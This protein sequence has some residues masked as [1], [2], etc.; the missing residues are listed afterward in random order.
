MVLKVKRLIARVLSNCRRKT[1]PNVHSSAVM[2]RDISVSSPKYLYL[3]EDCNIAKGAVIMNGSNGKFVMKKWSFSARELLVICGN[4]MPVVGVPLI[5]VTDAMKQQ[6]DVDHK[7]SA[8]VIVDEDVWIGARVTLMPGV[9]IG[10]GAIIAAGSVVTHCVPAY[11][12]WGGVPAKHIK[13]KW[14]LEEIIKHEK[15]LYESG[16]RFSE[17]ELKNIFD[18]YGK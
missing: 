12:V 18:K 15:I 11:S 4:H 7:Y 5:K 1:Y 3:G 16:S 10:R 14:T 6:L 13:F 9:H 8:D 2:A 17:E